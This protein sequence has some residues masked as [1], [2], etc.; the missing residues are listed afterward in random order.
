MVN[1][2]LDWI[3]IGG[4]FLRRLFLRKLI[5]MPIRTCYYK[6]PFGRG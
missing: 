3:F 6:I 2:L 4:N 5:A 1:Q